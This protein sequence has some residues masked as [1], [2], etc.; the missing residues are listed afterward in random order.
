[1][2]ILYFE[3][4]AFRGYSASKQ[5]YFYG[6]KVTVITNLSGHPIKM[7]IALG[8]EHDLPVLKILDSRSLP[9]ESTLYGK[10]A[11][12]DYEYEDSLKT[13]DFRLALD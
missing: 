1:M 11:Y 8:R 13:N 2:S 10:A 6:I 4:V 3:D 12:I 5:E 7:M 9:I